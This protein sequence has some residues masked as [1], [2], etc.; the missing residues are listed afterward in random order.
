MAKVQPRYPNIRVQLVGQDGNAFSIIGR[1]RVALRRG[2]VHAEAIDAFVQ[3][4][5]SGDYNHLLQTVMKWV[6]VD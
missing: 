3:E 4:A 6:S 1:T 2:G 5:T